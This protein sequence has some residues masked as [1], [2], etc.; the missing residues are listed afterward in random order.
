MVD[1][2]PVVKWSRDLSDDRLVDSLQVTLLVQLLV[3]LHRGDRK[4][5]VSLSKNIKFLNL[6]YYAVI[7]ENKEVFLIS[8]LEKP[9][10]K[11]ESSRP[12]HGSGT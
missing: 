10:D 5:A 1:W 3:E 7:L 6:H 2:A 8:V 11:V 9:N 4:V 12:D